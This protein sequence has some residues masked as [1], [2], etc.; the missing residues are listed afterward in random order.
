MIQDGLLTFV[1]HTTATDG[2]KVN[3]YATT[4]GKTI[5]EIQDNGMSM[6]V[7]IS[8]NFLKDSYVVSSLQE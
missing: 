3:E 2:R 6:D 4:F 5:F 8:N 1:G 7:D